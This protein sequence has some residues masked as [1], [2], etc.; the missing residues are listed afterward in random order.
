MA[1]RTIGFSGNLL[2]PDFDEEIENLVTELNR[3]FKSYILRGK[4]S[5]VGG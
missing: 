4:Q 2:L 5:G 3:V 1:I